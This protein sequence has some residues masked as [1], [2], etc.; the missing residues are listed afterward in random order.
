MRILVWL[1]SSVSVFRAAD[2]QVA[3]FAARLPGHEIE[4]MTSKAELVSGLA[5]ADA[6]V[7]WSFPARW[8][9]LAPRLCHVF[10]PAAGRERIQPD[11]RG[12]VQAHFGTFHG[13][14]MAE[15]LLAMMLFQNRRFGTAIEHQRAHRWEPTEYQ[16]TRRLSQ[17]TALIVGYG[18]IGRRMAELLT[19]V[20]MTVHGLKRNT[21]QGTAGV[22]H[23][24]APQE[25]HDAL[26]VADHVVCILPGDT[27]TDNLLD[28]SAFARMKPGAF[29]YNLG[30]G[31]AV[32]PDALADALR[33]GALAG[34]FLDVWPTEPLPSDSPLWD[35]PH[36]YLTP[37]ASAI[38]E[39]YL[40]LCFEEIAQRVESWP[41]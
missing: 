31:N 8:Y 6:V 11:P 21:A 37:H 16:G 7:V 10:T 9:E 40:D 22:A 29:V 2:V 30:R 38:Y 27:G 17:Q 5:E 12:R 36:L 28:R 41:P 33:S 34:A 20:G 39:E 1:D 3:R 14:M 4:R 24:Y 15:S 26:A 18:A 13:S 32:D 25:L 19:A 35:V 23:L